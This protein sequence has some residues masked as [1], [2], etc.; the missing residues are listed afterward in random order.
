MAPK[1]AVQVVGDAAVDEGLPDS[2]ALAPTLSP[3]SVT[4]RT[5]ADGARIDTDTQTA[6]FDHLGLDP[7]FDL[8]P[9]AM[10]PIPLLDKSLEEFTSTNSISLGMVG[11]IAVFFTKVREHHGG[12]APPEPVVRAP[13]DVAGSSTTPSASMRKIA[14]VLDQADEG[15][16]EPLSVSARALYRSNHKKL[17]GGPPPEGRVPTPE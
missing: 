5:L 14:A 3:S 1:A 6:L 13:A 9:A 4:L 7:E 2:Q 12:Q 11:R 17:T 10:I 8:A 15:H 16:F